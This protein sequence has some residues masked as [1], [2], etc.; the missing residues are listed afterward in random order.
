[1]NLVEIKDFGFSYPE[2]SRKVLEHVNLNIK[3]GTL[4]VIMGRSGCG[5]STLLRQLKS[6]LAP[7]GEKEGEILYRN[8]PLREPGNRV[9][10]A[11]SGQ[12]DRDR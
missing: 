3:E 6:V 7:A 11:K 2:S 10:D 12:P 1:M 9:C 8:I 4:N 5:K